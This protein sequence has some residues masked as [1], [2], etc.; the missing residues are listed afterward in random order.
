VKRQ[1]RLFSQQ[2]KCH[3]QVE[4]ILQ[5]TPLVGPQSKTIKI[6]KAVQMAMLRKEIFQYLTLN[7]SHSSN[8]SLGRR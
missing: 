1:S 5:A 4:K 8:S 7:P 2:Q 3:S 6:I